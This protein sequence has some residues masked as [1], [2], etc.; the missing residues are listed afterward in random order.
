MAAG[1]QSDEDAFD[2]LVLPDDAFAYL[3]QDGIG[4]LEARRAHDRL[5][6]PVVDTMLLERDVVFHTPSCFRRGETLRPAYRFT[7]SPPSSRLSTQAAA[8]PGRIRTL[9]LARSASAIEPSSGPGADVTS[10]I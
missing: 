3:A 9:R 1:E 8:A 6:R 4:E 2:D 7:R 10:S 5:D